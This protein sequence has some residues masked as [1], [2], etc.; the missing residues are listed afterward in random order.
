MLHREQYMD[1]L[2]KGTFDEVQAALLNSEQ[3]PPREI[4]TALCAVTSFADG[5]GMTKAQMRD[6]FEEALNRLE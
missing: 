4:F 3:D 6:L 5:E 1:E 2:I